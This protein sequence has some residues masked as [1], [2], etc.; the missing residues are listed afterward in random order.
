[1]I[2]AQSI[3]PALNEQN[4]NKKPSDKL[5]VNESSTDKP[6]VSLLI[7]VSVNFNANE[8]AK[9]PTMK[10]IMV[11]AATSERKCFIS[12]FF[13]RYIQA[14]NGLQP[15]PHA[16]AADW[17]WRRRGLCLGAKK[18]EACPKPVERSIIPVIVWDALLVEILAVVSFCIVRLTRRI[19][20]RNPSSF[21]ISLHNIVDFCHLSFFSQNFHLL[22]LEKCNDK[23]ANSFAASILP[24]SYAL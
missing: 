21:L 12:S 6:R 18:L 22:K 9:K 20:Y 17:P 10:R 8:P 19:F 7:K 5:G 4:A 15:A 11:I 14:A 24:E 2:Y 3:T 23:S 1:M 13:R 16:P